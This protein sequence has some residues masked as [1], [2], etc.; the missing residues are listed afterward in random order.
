VCTISTHYRRESDFIHNTVPYCTVPYRFPLQFLSRS[1]SLSAR[2]TVFTGCFGTVR[3]ALL[4]KNHG[5]GQKSTVR[6]A[7]DQNGL[8]RKTVRNGTVRYGTVR[9]G[10]LRNGTLRNG[11]VRYATVRYGTVR[12]ATVRY[13]TVRYGTLRY[14]TVRYGTVRYGTVRYGTVRYATVRYGMVRYGTER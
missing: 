4:R 12:Y 6:C 2:R 1:R 14:G 10:T 3:F 9:Y 11:T 13:G 5:H 8:S 7:V